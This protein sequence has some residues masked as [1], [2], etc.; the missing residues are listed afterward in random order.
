V[1]VTSARAKVTKKRE[2]SERKVHFS[3]LFR[4]PVTSARAKVTKK[5]EKSKR[6]VHYS[7]SQMKE[8]A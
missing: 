8:F 7:F 6:K 1:P 2:K 5:R 4:V 3:F